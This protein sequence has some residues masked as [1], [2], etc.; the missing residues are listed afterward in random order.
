MIYPRLLVYSSLA[1]LVFSFLFV[2]TNQRNNLSR[3]LVVLSALQGSADT[4]ISEELIGVVNGSCNT[5][6]SESKDEGLFEAKTYLTM[7]TTSFITKNGGVLPSDLEDT[8]LLNIVEELATDTDVNV[9]LWKCLGYEFDESTSAWNNNKVFPKWAL[10]FPE[11]PDLIGVTRKYDPGTDR[12]VRN[13]SMD[14][15]RSIPRDFKGGVRSLAS[16]GFKGYKLDELT[17]N[18]TRR[19]QASNWLIYY[20]EKLFGKSV[21]ELRQ[22]RLKESVVAP[23]IE[24]LPSEK[25]FQKLRLD[26]DK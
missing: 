4:K 8:N 7:S 10:K 12:R 21:E 24:A 23:E 11:P 9:L 25:Y 22:Q 6:K 19:A 18:K 5:C 15:M 20:R 1:S 26:S 16:V 13:A 2:K 14:L 3:K 17:P